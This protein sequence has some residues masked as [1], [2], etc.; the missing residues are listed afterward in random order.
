MEKIKSLLS[1]YFTKAYLKYPVLAGCITA[2]IFTK[3]TSLVMIAPDVFIRPSIAFLYLAAVVVPYPLTFAL[4]LVAM[5]GSTHPLQVFISVLVGSQVCFFLSKLITW[6]GDKQNRV[7]AMSIA[8]F[9][10]QFTTAGFK[11]ITGE[12]PFFSYL[13]LGMTKAAVA[14]IPIVVVGFG[15]LWLMEYLK[16]IDFRRASE[17]YKLK[18]FTQ[19]LSRFKR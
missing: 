10:A 16:V 6:R 9:L 15:A 19:S 5:I 17:G 12:M 1:G 3:N 14:L 4:P 11:T 8:T 2:Y 7:I 13:P 18:E